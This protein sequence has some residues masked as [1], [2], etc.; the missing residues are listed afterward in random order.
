MWKTYKI[1]F[2]FQVGFLILAII[3]HSLMVIYTLKFH[4]IPE[5][6]L[7]IYRTSE[8][9]QSGQ[10]I[11]INRPFALYRGLPLGAFC[12]YFLS[13]VDITLSY[14]IYI[15][16]SELSIIFGLYLCLRITNP[17]NTGIL[18]RI[19]QKW[20]LVGIFIMGAP[21]LNVL[22]TSQSTSFILDM[23][24]IAYFLT[25]NQTKSPRWTMFQRVIAGILLGLAVS[26]KLIPVILFFYFAVNKKWLE[27]GV[28]IIS[29]IVGILAYLILTSSSFLGFLSVWVGI[30]DTP[31][32]QLHSRWN[33]YPLD[34]LN[35][36]LETSFPWIRFINVLIW[37]LLVGFFLYTNKVYLTQN[38]DTN[39]QLFSFLTLSICMTTNWLM[40]YHLVM[41]TPAIFI[42]TDH[43]SQKV[44]YATIIVYS[45]IAYFSLVIIILNSPLV[46]VIVIKALAEFL[47]SQQKVLG[48]IG[49]LS[50]IILGWYVT[51][52]SP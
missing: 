33:I 37:V 52:S 3:V 8:L 29:N 17:S 44:Q 51:S 48:A 7:D 5:D 45:L 10:N 40:Y 18:E 49:V 36:P 31:F 35:A 46:E 50:L 14:P 38:K 27:I 20:L 9:L 30:N 41:I 26:I 34:F 28:S 13:S 15:C 1:K 21:V 2:I 25:N 22:L 11:Y 12:Y 4:Y 43:N 32:P 6:F 39:L 42:L 16:F 47:K 24:L 19:K 23:I